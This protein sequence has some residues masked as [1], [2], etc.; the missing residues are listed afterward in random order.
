ML[1]RS[2]G[3]YQ[4]DVDQNLLKEKLDEVVVS[5]VNRVGVN[6]N[7][8]SVHL[9]SY[10]SGIGHSLARNI[11]EYRDEH[12]PFESRNELMK[13]SRLGEKVYEQAAGFPR[14]PQSANPLDNSAVHPE[15]YD[16]V[17]RMA[18]D[19]NLKLSELIGHADKVSEIDLSKYL[20]EGEYT[21]KD[22]VAELAKPGRDPRTVIKVFEF[23]ESI[24]TIEDL[25]VG[26]ELPGIITNITNF[27]AFVDLGIK[28]NGLIHVSAMCPGKRVEDPTKFVKLH[29]HVIVEV[30][31]VD[32]DRKRIGL[33][34]KK[35]E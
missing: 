13:V 32:L 7:T 15:Q 17:K 20:S 21:V 14:V 29:Q 1:F 10:V 2:I 34:L 33:T 5:A 8:A 12:G 6:L 18:L 11:V 26:M 28:E 31:S 4:H 3:Q 35:V 30:K 27:G 9:L 24:H 22:I 23:S 25:A 16:L 19:L